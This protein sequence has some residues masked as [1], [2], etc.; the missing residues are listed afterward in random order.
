[1]KNKKG[2]TLIEVIVSIVLVS[3]VM[4]SMLS[5]LVKVRETY[6][7][8]HSNTDV[9]LYSSTI[10]RVLNNDITNNSGIRYINCNGDQDE[11]GLVL[12]NNSKR[13][14]KIVDSTNDSA[15]TVKKDSDGYYLQDA[16]G[17]YVR[18]ID[19]S[20]S[21]DFKIN[22]C[23]NIKSN[24]LR[25]VGTKTTC[26]CVKEI[27][28][29]TLKYYNPE[30]GD[31]LLYIKTLDLEQTIDPKTKKISTSGYNFL[32]FRSNQFQYMNTA[33][34]SID[35]VMSKF[36]IVLYDGID[37]NNSEY[38]IDLY[39]ASRYAAG[40]SSVGDKYVITLN[41]TSGLTT[42]EAN[43]LKIP[44]FQAN[45]TTT[46]RIYNLTE[47][48]NLEIDAVNVATGLSYQASKIIPPSFTSAGVSTKTFRGYYTESNGSGI[49]VIDET[50]N[51]LVASNFFDQD[52][53]LYS[54][55]SN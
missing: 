30:V 24:C 10:S 49:K 35:D 9:V 2:F 29:S 54:H 6:D 42:D 38:N 41:S 28:S 37:I 3:I 47:Q 36:T 11:C 5:T 32:N 21:S 27:H 45:P 23:T 1:M 8:V 4:A 31:K 48:Y 18:R 15:A 52:T 53:T 33:N 34:N 26:D 12:G 7:K 22:T 46:F 50:G 16:S 25:I 51:I 20:F 43:N 55:W 19:G 13:N 39:S 17:K 44:S 40:A 14:I